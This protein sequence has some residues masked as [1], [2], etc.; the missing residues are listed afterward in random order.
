VVDPNA[1]PEPQLLS[2]NTTVYG[3]TQGEDEDTFIVN[4]TEGQ[5]FSV[6]VIGMQLQ[7][8]N[9]YDPELIVRTPDGKVLK[10][11][12]STPFGRGNPVF[13]VN[14]PKTGEYTLSL[15][16]ATRSGVGDCHYLMHVGDFP[17]PLAALPGGGPASK[18]TAFTLIGDPKGDLRVTASPGATADSMGGILPLSEVASPTPVPVRISNLNNILE[19]TDGVM[20][21]RGDLAV[22]VGDAAVPALQKRMIRLARAMDK[23]TITATQMMESMVQNPVPTRA[24]VS[25][26][27]NAVLD[28][29]DAV[30]LS[31][32]TAAGKFPV[33]TI[34]ATARI[35]ARGFGGRIVALTAAALSQDRERALNAGCEGFYL[36]PISRAD[37]LAI[38]VG[39]AGSP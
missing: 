5:R 2:L 3:R 32:E 25:D 37:L 19:A 26:V 7:T 33:E 38:C 1:P 11:V 30:M 21:A 15:R 18:Q 12:G 34:E 29:T 17:R 8:Q 23:I 6:E 36:K 39:D 4:L 10:T 20:V 9:P 28:G 13:S 35:R 31:A 14:A 27:A 24:E 16:D 22:E